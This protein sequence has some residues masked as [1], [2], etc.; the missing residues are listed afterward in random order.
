[1]AFGVP[2]DECA[3]DHRM[4]SEKLAAIDSSKAVVSGRRCTFWHEEAG[5]VL[6]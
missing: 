1:M 3:E 5:S 6:L 4:P 2:L